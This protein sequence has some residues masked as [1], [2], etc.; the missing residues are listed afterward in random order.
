MQTERDENRRVRK[1]D[2]TE[3]AAFLAQPVVVEGIGPEL[4]CRVRARRVGELGRHPSVAVSGAFSGTG[5]GGS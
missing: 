2:H 4:A 1:A 5:E 3:D